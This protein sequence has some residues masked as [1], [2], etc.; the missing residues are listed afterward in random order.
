VKIKFGSKEYYDLLDKEPESKDYLA[1]GR[2]VSFVMK[3][4]LYEITE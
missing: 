2:N 3:N 1:L 4:K